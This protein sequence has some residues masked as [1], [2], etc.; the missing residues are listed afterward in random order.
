MPSKKPKASVSRRLLPKDLALRLEERLTDQVQEEE[1]PAPAKTVTPPPSPREAA[2]SSFLPSPKQPTPQTSPSRAAAP[3]IVRR[4]ER[5]ERSRVVILEKPREAMINQVIPVVIPGF[6]TREFMPVRI[7]VD[8]VGGSIM[9]CIIRATYPPYL[10]WNRDRRIK[11]IKE[12]RQDLAR[13]FEGYYMRM[14]QKR[15]LWGPIYACK[16]E[17]EFSEGVFRYDFLDY[18]G[19]IINKNICILEFSITGKLQ[20]IPGT[21]I[22]GRGLTTKPQPSSTMIS[23]SR[24]QSP[25]GSSEPP[26][27]IFILHLGGGAYELMGILDNHSNENF[28]LFPENHLLHSILCP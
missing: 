24:T 6:P 26:T 22:Y 3:G 4:T 17:L 14:D 5:T 9:H 18:V 8:R 27:L 12:F 10:E 16:R 2:P 11:K 25:G 21:R 23:R 15:E 1:L 20:S 19:K 13:N 7:G 28:T